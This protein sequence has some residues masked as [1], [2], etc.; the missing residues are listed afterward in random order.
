M[1]IWLR[2]LK[3]QGYS[4]SNIIGWGGGPKEHSVNVIQ[5]PNDLGC[6]CMCAHIFMPLI[7]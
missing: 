6:V 5:D 7:F 2:V 4:H 3:G 1:Y